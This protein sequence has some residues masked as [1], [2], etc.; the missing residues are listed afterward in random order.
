MYKNFILYCFYHQLLCE[1]CKS[2]SVDLVVVGPEDPLA[3][4]IADA[5]YSAGILCFGP[6]KQAARIESDKDWAK[7]F[8]DRQHIPTAKWKSFSNC[9]D[10][11]VFI[12]A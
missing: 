9:E 4:G 5:L 8:M 3:N 12:N 2:H 6:T 11:K 10:A 1:W 7:Q